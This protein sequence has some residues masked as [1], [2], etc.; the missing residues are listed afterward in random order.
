M[1]SRSEAAGR[2]VIDVN[3][4]VGARPGTIVQG[5]S[6]GLTVGWVDFILRYSTILLEQ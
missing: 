2:R 6:G 3:R 4:Y 1:R 5:D